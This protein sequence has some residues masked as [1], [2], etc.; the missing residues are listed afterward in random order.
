MPT[1]HIGAQKGDIAETILLPGDPLRAK[2]IAETFFEDV[3]L[4]SSVRNML[5]YTGTVNGKPVSIM[6]T[7]MGI[8]SMAICVNELVNEYGCKNLI[9]IGSFGCFD[10]EVKLG[11]L[12]LIQSSSTD[13]NFTSQFKLN[14]GTFSA[15]PSFDLLSKA[16]N[17]A[18]ELNIK[19]HVRSILCSDTFYFA[20]AS[21]DIWKNWASLGIVGVEMESY[22]LYTMAS[23]L[24]VNALAMATVSDH[25]VT[26][27][28]MSSDDRQLKF[29]EMMD[30]AIDLVTK[31]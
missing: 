15:A 12:C 11:E 18:D 1:P 17:S 28:V 9:R 23:Y 13:S 19:T 26:K 16:K 25:F 22:A 27:Q 8:P 4:V 29:K 21:K 14:N 24:N 6:G 30:V 5:V 7:G 2:F 3:K 31:L 10:P 20:E